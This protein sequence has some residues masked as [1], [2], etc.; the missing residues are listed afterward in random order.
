MAFVSRIVF[1][2]PGSTVGHE[3]EPATRDHRRPRSPGA[4]GAVVHRV[5]SE[6]H[7]GRRVKTGYR[8]SERAKPK[9]SSQSTSRRLPAAVPTRVTRHSARPTHTRGGARLRRTSMYSHR[10]GNRR[11]SPRRPNSPRSGSNRTLQRARRL[12]RQ[13]PPRLRRRS[14]PCQRSVWAR[15]AALD[16]GSRRQCPH[17]K[18]SRCSE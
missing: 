4:V 11:R 3:Q 2:G 13:I 18:T 6:A 15:H 5:L 7:G 12:P 16:D 8:R 10:S 17:H 14:K 1:T 9:V